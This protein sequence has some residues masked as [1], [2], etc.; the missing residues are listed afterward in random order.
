MNARERVLKD[1]KEDKDLDIILKENSTGTVYRAFDEWK[2]YA[3]EVYDKT[4]ENI[5]QEKQRLI[6]AKQKTE[7][8]EKE[9]NEKEY[10]INRLDTKITE[11]EATKKNLDDEIELSEE[12]LSFKKAKVNRVNEKLANLEERGLTEKKLGP[13]LSSDV[14]NV[15]ELMQRIETKEQH[16]LLLK[17]NSRLKNERVQVRTQIVNEKKELSKVKENVQS[18]E[19]KLDELKSKHTLW[20][21]A[22][23][24]IILTLQLGFTIETLEQIIRELHKLS[25]KGQPIT[26]A[27]RFLTRL[28][29]VKEEFGLEQAI[30]KASIKLSTLK[31]E[32]DQTRDILNTLKRDVLGKINEA[33]NK[34]IDSITSFSAQAK[35]NI[36]TVTKQLT[37]SIKNVQQNSITSVENTSSLVKDTI[38]KLET[39]LNQLF[40]NLNHSLQINIKTYSDEILS[41]GAIREQVGKLNEQIKLATILLGIQQDK[42]AILTLDQA[43]ITRLAERIDYFASKKHPE[44][45]TRAPKEIAQNDYGVSSLYPAKLPSLTK[46][47]VEALR[48]LERETQ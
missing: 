21:K 37:N 39:N 3:K 24:L 16:T 42:K 45:E 7:K 43:L 27:R 26:S 2:K 34:S 31:R 23:Q 30:Q 29:K 8:A 14:H 10:K 18:Q 5:S 15:E 28:A 12:H 36:E 4:Q 20:S 41:W 11:L 35:A 6:E 48:S 9:A 47:L 40:L 19:N 13:I 38:G 22:I 44:I 33:Q 32:L 25:I 17:E 1:M 46:W